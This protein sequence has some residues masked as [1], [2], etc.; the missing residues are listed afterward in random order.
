M[1]PDEMNAK[2]SVGIDPQTVPIFVDEP[3]TECCCR[4]RHK[5]TSV[6]MRC[7]SCGSVQ[8]PQKPRASCPG[9]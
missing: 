2:P 3:C 4:M 8:P 6:V 5:I 1:M 9:W 7:A